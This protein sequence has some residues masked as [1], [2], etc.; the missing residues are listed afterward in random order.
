MEMMATDSTICR[1][2]M[3]VEGFGCIT[4]MLYFTTGVPL[5]GGD[6]CT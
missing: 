4:R 6:L 1:E 3:K 2:V 5:R